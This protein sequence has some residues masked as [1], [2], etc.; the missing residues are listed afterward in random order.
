MVVS[1]I[2]VVDFAAG[3]RVTNRAPGDQTAPIA[4]VIRQKQELTWSTYWIKRSHARTVTPTISTILMC[5]QAPLSWAESGMTQTPVIVLPPVMDNGVGTVLNAT[6]I[7]RP[8]ATIRITN[9]TVDNV[10]RTTSTL[11]K[12][13]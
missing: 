6:T 13:L 7:H 1:S 3:F 5:S 8:L 10:T 11:I 9:L 2:L 12:R 4:T